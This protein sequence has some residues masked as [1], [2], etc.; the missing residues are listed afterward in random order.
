MRTWCGDGRRTGRH[1]PGTARPPWTRILWDVRER[2]AAAGLDL[3]EPRWLILYRVWARR[4]YAL[5][6]A[7]V[8]G[9]R[10]VEARTIAALRELLREAEAGAGWP[11]AGRK[12]APAP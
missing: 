10:E 1:R 4:F 9:V 6:L 5:P 11:G 2:A 3:V 7:P 12:V 8:P